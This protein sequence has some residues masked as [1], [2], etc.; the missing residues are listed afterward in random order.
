[1]LVRS[2]DG[3]AL[4]IGQLSHSWLS[5]QLARAWGNE[6]FQPPEP[7]EDVVLGAEQHDIGWALYDLEPQLNRDT[8]LPRGFLETTVEEHLAIWR[9]AP[10][11]LISQSLDAALVVSMHGRSL[12]Q[13]RAA[14]SGGEDARLL[15]EHIAAEQER[16]GLLRERLGM[17]EAQ[18]ERTRRQM[19]TWDGMS[20]ALCLDWRPFTLAD[21]PS[22]DGL[23]DLE[24]RHRDDGSCVVD[25]WPF[26]DAPVRVHCEARRLQGTYRDPLALREAFG[27]ARPVRLEYVLEPA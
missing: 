24:L 26:A 8:G 1:M 5:G 21:V 20:L 3:G 27:A 18:A 7:F 19:W 16:Q 25:P 14:A 9:D 12:S 6:R 22:R 11:R 10:E 13:L 17:S 2:E 15:E 23:L 4:A